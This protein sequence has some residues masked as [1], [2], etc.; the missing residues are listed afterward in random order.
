M[1]LSKR[2]KLDQYYTSKEVADWCWERIAWRYNLSCEEFVEPSAGNGSFLR[3]DVKVTAYDLE[4]KVSGIIE[5]D[6]FNC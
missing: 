3:E 1:L 4:P 2:N 5:K 6:F